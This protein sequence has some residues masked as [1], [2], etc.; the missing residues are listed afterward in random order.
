M[1]ASRVVMYVL[2]VGDDGCF[3]VW[4]GG[5]PP[6]L[7]DGHWVVVCVIS[8]LQMCLYVFVDLFLCVEI[9]IPIL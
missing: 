3:Y 8:L 4:F 5:L 9:R 2:C 7:P 1:V 6:C